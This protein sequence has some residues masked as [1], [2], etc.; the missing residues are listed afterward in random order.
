MSSN[1]EECSTGLPEPTQTLKIPP[2]WWG[3]IR[4]PDFQQ[5]GNEA[6]GYHLSAL[7]KHAKEMKGDGQGPKGR[8]IPTSDSNNPHGRTARANY[9]NSRGQGARGN[10]RK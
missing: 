1:D 2:W 3:A 4:E 9:L 10:R 6:M 8:P 5:A 7:N